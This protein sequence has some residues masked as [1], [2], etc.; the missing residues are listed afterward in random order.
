[1]RR[2]ALSKTCK[3]LHFIFNQHAQLHIIYG[4]S[5]ID[6][7]ECAM[8]NQLTYSNLLKT[9]RAHI[10]PV[11]DTMHYKNVLHGV[12][13]PKPGLREVCS[14]NYGHTRVRIR[15]R[16]WYARWGLRYDRKSCWER[17]RVARPVGSNRYSPASRD[18]TEWTAWKCPR[19]QKRWVTWVCEQ[20]FSI[21][22]NHRWSSGDIL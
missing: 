6:H 4:R 5:I 17:D 8:I 18:R 22:V 21:I 20:S 16:S 13:V 11:Y 9:W 19:I 14:R 3:L 2:C 1:M 15:G 10:L 7:V 12:E